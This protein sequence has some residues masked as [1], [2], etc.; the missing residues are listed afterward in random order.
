MEYDILIIGAGP[1]GSRAAILSAKQGLNVL[2][3][4]K[5]GEVGIP[6]QCG[7]LVSQAIVFNLKSFSKSCVVQK[8]D[9]QRTFLPDGQIK[10]IK[11]P[12][13]MLD[14]QKFDKLLVKEAISE[15][16]KL[17]LNTKITD[18]KNET[19]VYGQREGNAVE[20]KA[21]I[22]I[23]ADGPQSIVGQWINQ[24]NKNM[25]V[26]LQCTAALV[27]PQKTTDI[28]FDPMFTNGYGWVFP[29]NDIANVGIGVA[30]NNRK[31]LK[32]LLRIFTQKLEKSKVIK[33]LRLNNYT[34]G[35][36][37]VGGI[38]EFVNN[39]NILL[40]GDAGGF[41]H[42][43]TGA[44]ILTAVLSGEIAG[45]WAAKAVQGEDMSILNNYSTE[46]GKFLGRFLEHGLR[47]RKCMESHWYT[48][49]FSNLIR[50]S[51]ISFKEYYQTQDRG[52]G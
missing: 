47:K 37:P 14:R 49:D 34:A 51:W 42:P 45:K 3:V 20:I 15:G 13:F 19:L 27:N 2:M 6:V 21:K 1:A 50:N 40:A 28:Y 5:K 46:C 31:N 7:E 29:K 8:V 30:F 48:E 25:L 18:I 17:W 33:N 36:I 38:L 35:F 43:I 39:S 12:G 41:T 16:A 23:G 9:Y 11:A 26:G 32:E 24:Q 44:G 52:D 10:I 22:I 4:D